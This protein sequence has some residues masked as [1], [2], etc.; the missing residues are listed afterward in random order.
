MKPA[1]PVISSM[2][3]S[4]IVLGQFANFSAQA[5]ELNLKAVV[6]NHLSLQE[7]HGQAHLFI[8]TLWGQHVGVSALVVTATKVACLHQA[9]VGERAKAEVDPAQAAAQA[10][11]QAT[12]ARR[13]IGRD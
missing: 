11:S 6:L 7:V 4:S 12:L 1:A 5:L 9:L 8:D 10:T 3:S 13:G 2:R